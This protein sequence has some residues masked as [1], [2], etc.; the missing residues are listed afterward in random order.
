[1]ALLPPPLMS[2]ECDPSLLCVS[3]LPRASIHFVVR[4][5]VVLVCHLEADRWPWLYN[6]SSGS[7]PFEELQHKPCASPPGRWASH[8]PRQRLHHA[9]FLHLPTS[10]WRVSTY[11]QRRQSDCPQSNLVPALQN[12]TAHA[13]RHEPAQARSAGAEDLDARIHGMRRRQGAFA[14][15]EGPASSPRENRTHEGRC[16]PVLAAGDSGEQSAAR[17]RQ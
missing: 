3:L 5:A 14:M 6:S 12:H 17:A 1:M 10:V 7:W 16:R 15:D 8:R 9:P 13:G 4:Q 11:Q 2:R